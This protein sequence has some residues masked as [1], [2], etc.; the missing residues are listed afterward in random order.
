ML[1][2]PALL[3][4]LPELPELPPVLGAPALPELPPELGEP[5]L[6]ESFPQ[7]PAMSVAPM[8]SVSSDGRTQRP[9]TFRQ[10]RLSVVISF[11]LAW[12]WSRRSKPLPASRFR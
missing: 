4:E 2:I 6:P 9:G 10:M 8:T 7:P 3:P 12:S 1:G 5:A 11:Y